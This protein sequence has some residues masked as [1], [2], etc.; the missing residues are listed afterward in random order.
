MKK[1]IV[2]IMIIAMLLIFV[3]CE[4]T[5][6]NTTSPEEIEN[7]PSE[8]MEYL[9]VEYVNGIEFSYYRDIYT[10]VVYIFTYE[11][12]GYGGAGG[13]TPLLDTDGTPILWREIKSE[14][15]K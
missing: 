4:T 14:V 1:L 11:G 8:R 6:T 13:F 2:F 15:N 10:D 12:R 5:N 9:F 3:G 7:T